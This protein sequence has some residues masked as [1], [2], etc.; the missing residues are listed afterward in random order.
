M[1]PPEKRHPFPD[2]AHE[3]LARWVEE[4]IAAQKTSRAD[5]D[6]AFLLVDTLFSLSD[7][8][9]GDIGIGASD[10]GDSLLLIDV[11]FSLLDQAVADIAALTA[12][13]DAL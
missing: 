1:P 10:V 11:L 13:L 8:A 6:D 7:A 12:R 2:D 4:T 5:I 9:R 3:N